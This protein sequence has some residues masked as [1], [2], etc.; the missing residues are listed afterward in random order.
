[1]SLSSAWQGDG[2]GVRQAC[3]QAAA[4][5]SVR[6][7]Q[8]ARYPCPWPAVVEPVRGSAHPG[9]GIGPK[10]VGWEAAKA[11]RQAA[12]LCKGVATCSSST[13]IFDQLLSHLVLATAATPHNLCLLAHL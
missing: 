12:K 3:Q 2:R 10:G 11:T 9:I 1:M 8:F 5:L 13:T 4:F 7:P 6:R